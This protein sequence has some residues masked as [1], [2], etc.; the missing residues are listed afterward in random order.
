M[1]KSFF[2]IAQRVQADEVRA[3][4][5]NVETGKRDVKKDGF[6]P[7]SDGV[8][9]D[10]VQVTETPSPSLKVVVPTLT[11][12]DSLGQRVFRAAAQ[13]DFDFA[14]DQGALIVPARLYVKYVRQLTGTRPDPAGGPNV[15][16][17]RN[18]SH[19]LERDLGV[20]GSGVLPTPRTDE[21]I[22]LATIFIP[23][24]SSNITNTKITSRGSERLI[25]NLQSTF[26]VE[27]LKS[28]SKEMDDAVVASVAQSPSTV[29]RVALLSDLGNFSRGYRAD[30]KIVTTAATIIDVERADVVNGGAVPDTF[31]ALR[32]KSCDLSVAGVAAGRDYITTLENVWHAIYAIADTSA[33]PS[34]DNVIA[35]RDFGPGFGGT[36]PTLPG[37]FD[38]FRLIGFVLVQSSAVV[39]ARQI[40]QEFVFDDTDLT[41]A[42]T[43]GADPHSGSGPTGF[44][45][46]SLL[47]FV[48]PGPVGERVRIHVRSETTGGA[49]NVEYSFRSRGGVALTG[50]TGIHQ[51]GVA[52]VANAKGSD[53]EFT[54]H[55]DTSGDIDWERT[56]GPNVHTVEVRVSGLT[57]DL[58]HD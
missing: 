40:G 18:D 41:V 22:Q 13:P 57:L 3:A 54:V 11:A 9:M 25:Q 16:Y 53:Q 30:I 32:S 19:V 26:P 24:T 52:T 7:G 31:I 36:G 42:F 6:T 56:L 27:R 46:L 51:N 55:V 4:F 43:L 48:P 14:A 5:D 35:S 23:V 50:R 47:P 45:T 38:R 20:A 49:Q 17:D 21:S 8:L 58:H 2:H 33:G 10:V 29:N 12:W 28:M 15:D 1:N 37:T 34:A 44:V 39:P